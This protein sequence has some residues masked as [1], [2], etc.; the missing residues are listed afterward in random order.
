LNASYFM[1]IKTDELP[2]PSSAEPA[3]DRPGAGRR[4]SVLG[5]PLGYG[6]SMAGVDIG[7]AALR[8]ARINQR[9]AQ[10]G[11]EVRDL[12]DLRLERVVSPPEPG[13]KSK[14]L[15]EIAAACEALSTEVRK[16]IAA[17]ELPLVLGGDHSIAIGSLSGVSSH[18][19]ERNQSVGLIWFSAMVRPS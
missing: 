8:V 18:F 1:A 16:I 13:E 5:V 14:Y 19:R 12:G 6:A 2:M 7:P 10:L 15:K 11:F 3:K 17:G 9:I 4:V